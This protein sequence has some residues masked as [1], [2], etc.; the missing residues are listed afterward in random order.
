[1]VVMVIGALIAGFDKGVTDMLESI[2]PRSFYVG[3]WWSA[4]PVVSDGSDEMSPWRRRPPLTF[5]EAERL[6]ELPGVTFVVVNEGSAADVEWE[7]KRLSSVNIQGRDEDWPL[8][9]GGDVSPGRSFTRLEAVSNARVVVVNAKLAEQLFGDRDPIGRSIRIGGLPYD[10]IGVHN[11]PTGLFGEGDYPEALIPYGTLVKHVPFRPGWMHYF[12]APADN[13]T[14]EEAID[15]VTVAL[16]VMRGL[17]PGEANTFDVVTQ[18]RYLEAFNSTTMLFRVVMFV[19][20]SVGLMVGGVGVVA[21]M[22]ISVT[23]RTR[24]IGVRK[25]LGATKREIMWQFLVEA[26]TLT[27]VGGIVGM[28]LGGAIAYTIGAVS[29]VPAYV[30]ITSI[31]A[32]LLA[33][34]FT[35]I[36]FGLYPASRAARLDPVE[37]LRYE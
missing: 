37:A 33:A 36:L 34:A 3:R 11:P 30:P 21:I 8:V 4:G 28:I 22:M 2:G 13:V 5:E 9:S 26:A 17:R 27:L 23:E 19:L 10:V 1:M 18:E 35:G 29:P 32:A 7:N 16:R 25:A 14:V 24:E 6:E 12:V 31:I 15:Q 20:S